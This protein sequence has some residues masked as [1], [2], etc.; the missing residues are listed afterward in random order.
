MPLEQPFQHG[1]GETVPALLLNVVGLTKSFGITKALQSAT[2][3]VQEGSIHCLL[4]EN[5]AGKSTIGKIVSGLYG[6]DGGK[7]VFAGKEVAPKTIA[8]ARAL[9]IAIVFQELSLAP[10]LSV[11]ENICLG[12]ESRIGFV[13]RGQEAK[14]CK[15]LLSSLG[16]SGLDLDRPV[17][18][19]PVAQQQLIEIAK[20]LATNPRLIVLDEPTA[21]LGAAEKHDL[22][23]TIRRLRDAGKTFIFVTHLLDEV[24]ELG[25]FVSIL[26]DGAVIN[27]FAME[28]G[29]KV[30]DVLSRMGTTRAVKA[31]QSQSPSLGQP[32]FSASIPARTDSLPVE[33]RKG[34]IV[35]LYGV[36][37]CGREE[38][39]QAISGA[40]PSSS[41]SMTLDGAP[42]APA[43]TSVAIKHGVGYLATGRAANGILPSMSIRSNLTIGQL[44]RFSQA[45]FIDGRRERAE[46]ETQLA[47]LK[48]RM[49]SPEDP[50]TS[51][52]GGNQQKVLLGRCFETAD[53]LLVLE[54]PTAGIDLSAKQEIHTIIRSR[55]ASGLA[56][57]L[58][59]SDLPETIALCDRVYTFFSG[60]VVSCYA[61]EL[62]EH[63]DNIVANI[64]GSRGARRNRTGDGHD[65]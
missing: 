54:D 4:G 21:M 22:Y 44:A 19:L 50:I 41:F 37:G 8:E 36:V 6:A 60:D 61:G 23:A 42:F 56:V 7:I 18:E 39:A 28:K 26:R 3:S 38:L 33:I 25:D 43:R 45:G 15:T 29:L 12:N 1:I 16:L 51:L 13:H 17:G 64:L 46:T 32:F 48:T 58:I 40:R 27:S 14:R 34:E 55:A 31:S 9:G 24:V 49:R 2:L 11:V 35:G 59:S 47:L 57:L 10:H 53:R 20:A 65:S 30:D 62:A 52:S 63:Q 5:G